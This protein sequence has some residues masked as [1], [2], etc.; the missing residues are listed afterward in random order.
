[1]K[2]FALLLPLS[3]VAACASITGT[4]TFQSTN[5]YTLPAIGVVSGTRTISAEGATNA[6]SFAQSVLN[7]ID[8]LREDEHVDSADA[9]I[10]I[11]T[12]RLASDTT[13]AGVKAIRLRLVTR[14][15]TIELCDRTL[16]ASEERSASISCTVD[17]EVNE[18]DLESNTSATSPARITVELDVSGTVTATQLTS[19]V[20][21][22][23]E[24]NAEVSL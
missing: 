21:F 6:P 23:V 5:S 8:E 22:E 19:T 17:H 2:V 9:K 12:V 20:A 3:C 7:D 1:M 16:S 4:Q 10:R 11:A 24:V 18:A 15:E 14:T 13:F